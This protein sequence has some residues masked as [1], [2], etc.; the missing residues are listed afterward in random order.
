MLKLADAAGDSLAGSPV[1]TPGGLV[2]AGMLPAGWRETMVGDVELVAHGSVLDE[3]APLLEAH[4]SLHAWAAAQPGAEAMQGRTTSWATRLPAA[5]VD[6]VVRHSAHGGLLAPLTGDRF[7]RPRAPDE[8][9]LA[10]TL[11]QVGVPTPRVLAYAL[12]PAFGRV[13]WRADV[14]TQ[15]VPGARDLVDVLRAGPTPPELE[16]ILHAVE[17]LLTAMRT[18]LA[19]HPDLNVKNI[20]LAPTDDGEPQAWVLDVDTVRF[21]Q[22]DAGTRN[23]ARLVRS[24][25][26]WAG[27]SRASARLAFERFAAAI[28]RRGAR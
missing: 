14:M 11:R 26:K 7:R 5:G 4:G 12:H 25:R 2:P 20:L 1:A 6:V 16:A 10:W 18:S 13:L 15:R 21:A 17:T 19:H 3:V 22:R 28:E 9:R 27:A 24:A 23:R 8:L